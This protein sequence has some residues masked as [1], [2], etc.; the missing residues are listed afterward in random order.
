M[1]LSRAGRGGARSSVRRATAP[2]IAAMP[3]APCARAVGDVL[4]ADAA[5][6]ID[7]QRHVSSRSAAKPA[8][9]MPVGVR[10]RRRVARRARAPRSRSRSL[11]RDAG[12]RASW[13]DAATRRVRRRSGRAPQSGQL[14][15]AQ[16]HA[17]VRV[18]CAS[19]TSPLTSTSA[20]MATARATAASTSARQRAGAQCGCAQLHAADAVGERA[21]ERFQPR[22]VDAAG[23]G[24]DEVAIGL[25]QR[26]DHRAVRRRHRVARQL[27]RRHPGQRLAFVAL[28]GAAPVR[29]PAHVQAQALVRIALRHAISG[30]PKSISMP[31]SSCSS[32]A[33]AASGDLARFALAAGE[34][35]EA[36]QVAAF[37]AA[38][39][40][41][42]A[43][44]VADDARR[45]RRRGVGGLSVNG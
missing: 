20:A 37:G 8:Q 38:R 18:R 17:D 41:D 19:A 1:A 39:Q 34:F 26:G 9:P 35:P 44:L 21:F 40:Q 33:S 25:Q 36:G 13:Q 22:G 6:R 2:R 3:C 10:M 5:D 29:D 11:R 30:A 12:R 31:S 42:A 4:G 14:R 27:V 23:R 24:R 7:R 28:H 16:V 45:R 43:A 32:R 15:G